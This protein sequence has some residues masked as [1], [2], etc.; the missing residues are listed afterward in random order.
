M[1]DKK[2]V[3]IVETFGPLT[4]L[5]EIEKGP[6]IVEITGSSGVKHKTTLKITKDYVKSRLINDFERVFQQELFNK[7]IKLN[8]GLKEALSD[9]GKNYFKETISD[10][11]P[12]YKNALQDNLK[13]T[14]NPV[15]IRN[16]VDKIVQN[17]KY[18]KKNHRVDFKY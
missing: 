17:K 1:A 11:F 4:P 14:G 2:K 7:G 18:I 13:F 9:K 16:V 6:K 3:K 5:K 8:Y 10:L 12:Q 15:A